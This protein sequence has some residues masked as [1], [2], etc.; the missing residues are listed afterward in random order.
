MKVRTRIGTVAHRVGLS[1]TGVRWHRIATEL[2]SHGRVL[3]VI[4]CKGT[5]VNLVEWENRLN[6]WQRKCG[7]CFPPERV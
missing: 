5:A 6:P 7:T 2:D 3:L 1:Y 4:R